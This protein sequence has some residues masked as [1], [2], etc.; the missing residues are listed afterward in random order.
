MMM[1]CMMMYDDV[2]WSRGLCPQNR[3]YVYMIA[4]LYACK[5]VCIACSSPSCMS[6]SLSSPSPLSSSSSKSSSPSS[7]YVGNE[8]GPVLWR[9]GL[10]GGRAVVRFWRRCGKW[11][12]NDDDDDNSDDDDNDD[13]V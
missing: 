3:R 4:S 1:L 2:G 13:D 6:P 8:D 10:L 12:D 11:G 7:Y 9:G 5:Y